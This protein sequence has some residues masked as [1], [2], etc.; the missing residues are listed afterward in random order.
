M[1]TFKI[2]IQYKHKMVLWMPATDAKY[3]EISDKLTVKT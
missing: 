1:K 2:A 3:T